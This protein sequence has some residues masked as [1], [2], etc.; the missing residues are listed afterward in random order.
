MTYL[1]NILF[2]LFYYTVSKLRVSKMYHVLLPVNTI[3]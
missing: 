1:V 3:S 2:H